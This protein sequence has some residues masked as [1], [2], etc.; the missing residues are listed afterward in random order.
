M[1]CILHSQRIIELTEQNNHLTALCYDLTDKLLLQQHMPLDEC[2]AI[3]NQLLKT[4]NDNIMASN[5][6]LMAIIADNKDKKKHPAG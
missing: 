6:L 5:K 1:D 3:R 2:T 4:V